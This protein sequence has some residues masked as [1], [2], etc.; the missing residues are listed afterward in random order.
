VTAGRA[1]A[2]APAC[3]QRR[4]GRPPSPE[5]HARSASGRE[6]SPGQFRRKSAVCGWL[7][8][9]ST[10]RHPQVIFRDQESGWPPTSTEA[11]GR[12]LIVSQTTTPVR[13]T[14]TTVRSTSTRV[15]DT[16]RRDAVSE[17]RRKAASSS[18]RAPIDTINRRPIS[19]GCLTCP[20]PGAPPISSHS[21]R[22]STSRRAR[23]TSRN[24]CSAASARRLASSSAVS[25]THR[26]C[27]SPSASPPGTAAR[28]EATPS[29]HGGGVFSLPR[30][31]RPRPHLD[32]AR[33]RNRARVKNRRVATRSRFSDI[34]TCHRIPPVDRHISRK[35]AR[36]PSH[37]D[38]GQHELRGT[39]PATVVNHV[40]G[41]D[42]RRSD[43]AV[44]RG[45]RAGG[46]RDFPSPFS[47]PAELVAARA[48]LGSV[49]KS[50]LCDC[51]RRPSCARQLDLG[52]RPGRE[53]TGGGTVLGNGGGN[54]TLRD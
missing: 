16:S 7:D 20:T 12:S 38:K 8:D 37:D 25:A 50:S 13:A 1:R 40:P 30:C 39:R 26:I 48:N 43:E 15:N 28:R 47:V 52:E 46:E 4:P 9:R 17:D 36:L 31:G 21:V 14:S 5:R 33:A 29:E 41:P 32:P 35:S 22:P 49:E 53:Q 3:R 24:R 34:R 51:L 19:I 23:S 45:R 11:Y 6:T 18:L 27:L 44:A 10:T 54:E 42:P 2:A